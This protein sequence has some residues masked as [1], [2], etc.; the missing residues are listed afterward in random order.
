VVD[1]LRFSPPG[2]NELA[3]LHPVDESFG[4]IA[5]IEDPAIRDFEKWTDSELHLTVASDTKQLK[6]VRAHHLYSYWQAY[7]LYYAEAKHKISIAV[8]AAVQSVEPG[9]RIALNTRVPSSPKNRGD[10]KG[11]RKGMNAFSIFLYLK[12]QEERHAFEAVSP[13]ED[14]NSILKDGP[15]QSHRG[16]LKTLA[17]KALETAGI[18][19]Q[20]IL[21]TI[22]AM[23]GI[24]EDL[25]R[26]ERVAL[27]TMAKQDLYGLCDMMQLLDGVSFVKL[28][29]QFT[30]NGQVR[31]A[32]TLQEVFPNPESDAEESATFVLSDLAEQYNGEVTGGTRYGAKILMSLPARNAAQGNVPTTNDVT[33]FLTFLKSK[34]LFDFVVAIYDLNAEWNLPTEFH[35]YRMLSLLRDVTTMMEKFLKCFAAKATLGSVVQDLFAGEPWFDKQ[36]FLIFS[37]FNHANAVQD[38]QKK[39]QEIA[40]ISASGL[41]PGE[42][43]LRRCVLFVGLVRNVVHHEAGFPLD[44]FDGQYVRILRSVSSVM[45]FTWKHAQSKGQISAVSSCSGST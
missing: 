5:D 41:S 8:A 2:F 23:A 45:F 13:D 35:E 42:L 1:S 44:L 39:A 26:S 38:F 34:G 10:A 36:E 40:G 33:D 9:A 16:R 43:F 20:A 6:V 28:M 7:E 27:A 15:L 11:I 21:D 32:N 19:K 22:V 18:N 29:H 3:R 4:K 25:R 14:G 24:F 30:L 37:R 12:N 31:A 17:E